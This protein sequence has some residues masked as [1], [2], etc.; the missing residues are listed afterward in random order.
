MELDVYYVAIKMY[1]SGNGYPPN[2]TPS[3]K[4][5]IR[6]QARNYIL[7]DGELYHE[8]GTLKE[9]KKVVMTKDERLK[10]LTQTHLKSS[11]KSL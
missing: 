8:I 3:F 9:L 6:D 1:V 2:S 5:L 7:Q 10:L 11:S 4:R